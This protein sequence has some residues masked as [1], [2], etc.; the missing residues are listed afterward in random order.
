LAPSSQKSG[1]GIGNR[2]IADGS[3]EAERQ[4][5]AGPHVTIGYRWHERPVL[6]K[7][8]NIERR[9]PAGKMG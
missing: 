6:L 7:R 9:R 1:A 5:G 8:Q 4:F 3:I 2:R